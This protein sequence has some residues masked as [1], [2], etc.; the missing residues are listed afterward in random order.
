MVS[1]YLK[2]YLS[3]TYK[4]SMNRL[5]DLRMT[6]IVSGSKVRDHQIIYDK[7][8][9]VQITIPFEIKQWN[10]KRNFLFT[11]GITSIAFVMK[12]SR[13]STWIR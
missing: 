7:K 10:S 6:A 1:T 11:K 12:I 9:F 13:S 8:W 3:V 5:N 2:N 4:L